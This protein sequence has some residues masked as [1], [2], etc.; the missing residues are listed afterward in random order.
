MAIKSF[1][2]KVHVV[3]SR[4]KQTTF[5]MAAQWPLNAKFPCKLRE[6][7]TI[8][9]NCFLIQPIPAPQ[10]AVGARIQIP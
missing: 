10:G 8:Q 9:S 4:R 2:A 6:K 7:K 3:D 5:P 1:P